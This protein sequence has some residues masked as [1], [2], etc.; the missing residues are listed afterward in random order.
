MLRFVI[1]TLKWKRWRKRTMKIRS[2]IDRDNFQDLLLTTAPGSAG[3]P[4]SAVGCTDW[5]RLNSKVHP[6]SSWPS[7]TQ[8]PTP[9]SIINGDKE[10]NHCGTW[11]KVAFVFEQLNVASVRCA[12]RCCRNGKLRGDI[13]RTTVKLTEDAKCQ[14]IRSDREILNCRHWPT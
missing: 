11:E 8:P 10:Q 3:Q 1:K 14:G 7:F 5:C 9:H 2:Y 13:C 12:I 4:K 6:P